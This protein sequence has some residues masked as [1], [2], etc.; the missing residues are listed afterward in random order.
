MASAAGALRPRGHAT[1]VNGTGASSRIL[2]VTPEI[3]DF[4]KAGGLGD[5]S[6]ALPRALRAARCDVRILVPGYRQVLRRCEG[7]EIVGRLDGVAGIPP[8]EVGQVCM[9][10]G[11]IAYIVLAPGLYDREG[12]P[13]GNAL[14]G[15]WTDNDIRFSRLALAAADI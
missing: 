7:M 10:D 12:S 8:C 2:Y 3:S 11:L 14:G 9:S 15:D 4:V 5:V 6:A 1:A 13:Y